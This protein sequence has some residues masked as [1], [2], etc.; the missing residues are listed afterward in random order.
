VALGS[1]KQEFW[2]HAHRGKLRC[3]L[4]MGLGGSIDVFAGVAKRAPDFFIRLNL[5]WFYRLLRQPSRLG[6][7]MKLPK[8][9]LRAIWARIFHNERNGIHEG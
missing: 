9:V 1:P 4:M 7:M 6:R 8:Y 2:M 5:E 3:G